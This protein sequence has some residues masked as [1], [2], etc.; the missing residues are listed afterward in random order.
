MQQQLPLLLLQH[1]VLEE[2]AYL[3]RPAAAGLS[4]TRN[5][6]MRCRHS[7]HSDNRTVL[8][9][10]VRVDCTSCEQ[11]RNGLHHLAGA[12][13]MAVSALEVLLWSAYT[14]CDKVVEGDKQRRCRR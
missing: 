9:G 6:A 13:V 12:I 4:G 10:A 5:E 11:R 7:W 8:W 3:L 2:C 1:T 14:S